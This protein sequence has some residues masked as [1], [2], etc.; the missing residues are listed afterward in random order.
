MSLKDGRSLRAL[1]YCG[2][3]LRRTKCLETREMSTFHVPGNC[4]RRTCQ[5]QWKSPNPISRVAVSCYTEIMGLEL[6]RVALFISLKMYLSPNETV[7]MQNDPEMVN[8]TF[9]WQSIE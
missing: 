9:Q 8:V 7:S 5:Q 6:D 3:G 2:T 4:T 1:L